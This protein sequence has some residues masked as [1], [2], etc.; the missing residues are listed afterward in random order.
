MRSIPLTARD[1]RSFTPLA[2]RKRYEDDIEAHQRSK[3]KGKK[4]ALPVFHIAVPTLIERET[5]G[6]L[7]F[8]L[9]MVQVTRETVRNAVLE[10]CIAL[11]GDEGEDTALFL[12]TH[13][14]QTAFYEDQLELWAQQEQ[15]RLLDE[16]ENPATKRDAIA[17]P[18]QLTTIQDRMRAKRVVDDLVSRS[19]RIRRLLAAQTRYGKESEIMMLRLHLRGWEGLKTNRSAAGGGGE[20][21]LVSEDAITNLREEIGPDAWRELWME[22]D[23]QY[24]LGAEEVGN[25]DSRPENGSQSTGST[26]A[27]EEESGASPGIDTATKSNSTPAPDPESGTTTGPS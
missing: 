10:E 11:L 12:E 21:E 27:Q 23:S 5:I 19:Q 9:G 2:L 1:P 14:Q 26:P 25:S 15:Q 13:W 8:E 20:I 3:S 16:F 18:V 4:P 7:M 6:S 22:V 17:Q 24:H